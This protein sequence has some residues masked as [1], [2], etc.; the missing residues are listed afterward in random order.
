MEVEYFKLVVFH[1]YSKPNLQT[2]IRKKNSTMRCFIEFV[3]RQDGNELIE[4]FGETSYD[5]RRFDLRE[6]KI[7]LL[8]R[9]Y[10]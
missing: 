8:L 10:L 9:I 7:L 3:S 5:R 6:S 4:R 1:Y 2:I